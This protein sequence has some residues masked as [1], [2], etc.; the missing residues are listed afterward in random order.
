MDANTKRPLENNTYQPLTRF[1]LGSVKEIT[2]I[3]FPLMLSALS[4]ALMMFFDRYILA[5]YSV[6]SM[7]AAA[8]A[9][10]S[11]WVFQ[12]LLLGIAGIAE[13]FVGQYNG[14]KQYD[15]IASPVWQMIWFSLLFSL[16]AIPIAHLLPAYFLPER[17][18]EQGSIY[19]KWVLSFSPL[20]GINTAL[21]AFYVGRGKVKL[22]TS[23]MILGNILNIILDILL[24]FGVGNLL[25]PLGILGAALATILSQVFQIAI[26]AGVFFSQSHRVKYQT[27]K[28]HLCLNELWQCIKIGFPSALGHMIEI[29]A[30]SVQFHLLSMVGHTHATVLAIG[31]SI[32]GLVAFTSEGINKGVIAIASNLLGAKLTK[33]IPKVFLSAFWLH[34]FI[35]C[36]VIVPLVF[37]PEWF[38]EDFI[39]RE[40]DPVQFQ[41]ILEYASISCFWIF[42]YFIFDGLVWISAGFLMAAKDTWYILIVNAT[43]AWVCA[44]IPTYIF[45]YKMGASPEK[46][47]MMITLYGLVNMMFFVYRIKTKI[48]S[49]N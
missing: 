11:L 37:Y 47:W 24:V 26:L 1:P 20:V 4:S 33:P 3:S 39:S 5:H 28:P 14:A 6:D 10:L 34:L 23:V 27:H 42:A 13:V 16:L 29:A 48:M 43:T 38:I 18:T 35:A 45:V 7:N 22:I 32:F 46:A 17:Y 44:L 8:G 25:K 36:V 15:K 41:L 19:F 9:T 2:A 49:S 21:T 30:W 31:Q 40:S 12:L